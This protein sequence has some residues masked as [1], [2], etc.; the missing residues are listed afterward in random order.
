MFD[1]ITEPQTIERRGDKMI[2]DVA[3]RGPLGMDQAMKLRARARA[4]LAVGMVPTVVDTIG[5]VPMGRV[6]RLTE[7][8]SVR[9]DVVDTASDLNFV[10]EEVPVLGKLLQ[11][12]II[13]IAVNRD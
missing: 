12:K 11:T 2:V 10:N 5:D 9:R 3:V 13:T 6:S 7:V 4:L 8:R 1:I